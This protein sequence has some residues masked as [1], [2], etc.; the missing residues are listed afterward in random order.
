MLSVS[1]ISKREK[2]PWGGYLRPSQFKQ[3]VLKDDNVLAANENIHGNL[4]GMAVDYL[5]RYML[6]EDIFDVFDIS[7]RGAV[8]AEEDGYKNAEEIAISLLDGI[9]ELDDKS[10]INA[11]KLVT[12]DVWGRNMF[13]A[14]NTK[15]ADEID[16]DQDTVN[17]IRIMVNRCLTFWDKDSIVKTGF[18][19]EPNGYSSWCCTGDGD[20]LTS[21]AIWDLKV[22][23]SKIDKKH[24]LQLLMYWIMGQHSGKEEF[25][26]VKYI[27]FFNPRSNTVYIMPVS[28]IPKE[29]IH[30]VEEKVIRY[31]ELLY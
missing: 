23:R 26:S 30:V 27:G 11:C 5:T 20:Y 2:Q 17:N 31:D 24:T 8:R 9:E 22:L 4:V 28:S 7:L 1:Q 10:I 29:V 16:P 3:I 12:F 6:G 14:K 13:A 15:K 25:K 18:T 19:F 21:D